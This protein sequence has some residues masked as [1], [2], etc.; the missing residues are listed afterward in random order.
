MLS[1]VDAIVAKLFGRRLS[2][3]PSEAV[4]ENGNECSLP[5]DTC[6]RKP[7]LHALFLW[8]L[9][10]ERWK[11]A[12]VFWHKCVEPLASA[13]TA[14]NILL[15]MARQLEGHSLQVQSWKTLEEQQQ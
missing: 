12:E 8:A 13:V 2:F 15:S 14:G 6:D 3:W 5:N 11:L 10:T 9:L 4:I 7:A 1:D